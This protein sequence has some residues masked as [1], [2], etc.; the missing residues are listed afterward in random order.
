MLK[1]VL[2]LAAALSVVFGGP[3]RAGDG[4]N[5]IA[6]LDFL[7][8]NGSDAVADKANRHLRSRL[9]QYFGNAFLPYESMT[10]A[11]V[12][13]GMRA[14]GDI[15]CARQVAAVLPVDLVI[16]GRMVR[17]TKKINRQLGQAGEKKYLLAENDLE[18]YVIEV[19]MVDA[20]RN[21]L[22]AAIRE[23]ASPAEVPSVMERIAARLA[24]AHPKS[25]PLENK[26]A[27]IRSFAHPYFS[28]SLSP[29]GYLPVGAMGS[30]A[31]G[32]FGCGLTLGVSNALANGLEGRLR[33]AY[34]YMVGQSA[35]LSRYHVF[36][37][38]L[39]LGYRWSFP[40]DIGFI[41]T[42]GGG[43]HL[44]L[45]SRDISILQVPG[46]YRYSQHRYYD[47]HANIALEFSW[48]FTGNWE[49]LV[50]PSY[51]LFFERRNIGMYAGIDTGIRYSFQ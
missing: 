47:P 5:R 36:P 43:Y 17:V 50:I 18:V 13:R 49:L 38:T 3:A 24:A 39:S 33:G 45:L 37:V 35:D 26:P 22:V 20:Q 2:A 14:C 44:H 51:T 12:A 25:Q 28:I 27:D 19:S 15:L 31:R 10:R 16:F 6:L 8:A 23:E 30:M 11:L 1:S 40:H 21:R 42:I 41:P 46:I 9:E 34:G 7:P 4:N 29:A 48:R 32:G